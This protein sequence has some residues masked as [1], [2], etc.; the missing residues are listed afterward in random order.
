[1]SSQQAP[2]PLLPTRPILSSQRVSMP[3]LSPCWVRKH[4]QA[5]VY[6]KVLVQELEILTTNGGCWCG[7]DMRAEATM[8]TLQK[9]KKGSR[10]RDC[11]GA[12]SPAQRVQRQP[13]G[14]WG[15]TMG[16]G[17]TVRGSW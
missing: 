11:S 17:E 10:P 12:V 4:S 5:P 7:K 15:E 6:A 14:S 3:D 1:M 2:G 9:E 13:L 8:T 16:E